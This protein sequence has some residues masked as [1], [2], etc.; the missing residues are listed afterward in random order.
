VYVCMYALYM[1][2]EVCMY[3]NRDMNTVIIITAN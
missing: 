2:V 3:T 1:C